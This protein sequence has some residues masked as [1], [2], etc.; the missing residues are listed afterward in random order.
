VYALRA[1]NEKDEKDLSQVRPAAMALFQV[2]NGRYSRIHMQLLASGGSG[3]DA[4]TWSRRPF[5][6]RFTF[7]EIVRAWGEWKR[8]N[9]ADTA[10]LTLHITDPEV[11]REIASGRIDVGELLLAEDLRFWAEIVER[12]GSLERRLF[13]KLPTATLADLVD[14][15]GLSSD[16]WTFDVSPPASIENPHSSEVVVSTRLDRTLRDLRLMP[17]GTLHFHR[18]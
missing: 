8:G 14:E 12:D 5:P 2:T 7:M 15:L 16:Y 13:H 9:P 11:C 6:A 10:C 3:R 1:R 4:A 17:G 18:S